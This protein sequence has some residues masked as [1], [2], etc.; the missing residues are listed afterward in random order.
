MT[1]TPKKT[2][3][4]KPAATKPEPPA[5]IVA[6]DAHWA[7]TRARLQNRTRPTAKLTICDDHEVK[8][9]L[10]AAQYAQNRLRDR[11]D[12]DPD[13]AELKEALEK[14]ADD[15]ATAQEAFDAVALVLRFEAL[16]RDEFD[17]L[18]AEHPPTE[19]QAD[20][21]ALANAETIGPVLISR[22][23]LDGITEDDASTY[24]NTWAVAEAAQLFQAAWDVQQVVRFDVGKG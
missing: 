1:T 12:V 15:V 8:Q 18:K 10:A 23:S 13:N 21:G 11:A 6:Q 5:A 16:P 3:A 19:T 22:C 9:A 4:T 7:A 24:L 20:E 14:A 2:T 17:E